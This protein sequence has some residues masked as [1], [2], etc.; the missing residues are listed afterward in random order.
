MAATRLFVVHG[1]HPCAAIEKALQLKGVE[2]KVF[3]WTPPSH[4]VG[5]RVLFGDRT[6][7]GIRFADGLKLQGSSTIMEELDRRMPTPLLYTDDA[8]REAERWGEA[9]FQAIARR[10]VWPAFDRSPEAMWSF[11][12]GSRLPALPLPVVKVLRPGVTKIERRLNDA[13]DDACA[14][15][16]DALPG[17][18][19]RIDALIADGVLDSGEQPN[20]ADLQIG[21][22][23]NLLMAAED[24]LPLIEP[25]PAGRLARKLYDPIPGRI[26]VGTL[27]AEWVPKSPAAAA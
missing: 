11:Q 21:A 2:Y 3:E 10:I 23:L 20:A 15:D 13:S 1:S 8:V 4:A 6:V 12:Q 27:P 14:A 5:M 19:D 7:P 25:R 26:P 18:L 17:N 9:D 22:T 16:L 24:L